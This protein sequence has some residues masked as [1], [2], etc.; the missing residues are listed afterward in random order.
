MSLFQDREFENQTFVK[1]LCLKEEVKA[2][3][4]SHCRFEQGDFTQSNWAGSRLVDCAMHNCNLSLIK[5][6]GCRLQ[7]LAFHHCKLV[8]VNFGTCNPLFLSLQFYNCII[9]MCNFSDLNLKG[10]HFKHCTMRETHFT[11][12]NLSES[13]FSGSDLK[14]SLFHNSNLSKANFVGAINYSINPLTNVL[15]KARFSQPEAIALL[16]SLEII[17]E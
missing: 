9:D 10:A 6:D 1:P 14:N 2:K 4:F 8:G 16:E 11:H 3:L 7:G 15:K 5:I 17:I 13:D 12:T